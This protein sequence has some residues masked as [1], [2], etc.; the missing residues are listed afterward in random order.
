MLSLLIGLGLFILVP[1]FLIAVI[2]DI[3]M[4]MLTFGWK[5]LKLG[6]RIFFAV[7]AGFGLSLTIPIFMCILVLL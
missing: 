7:L 4:L 5:A 2:F 1:L 3:V 6:L